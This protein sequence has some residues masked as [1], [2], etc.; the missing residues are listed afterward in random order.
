MLFYLTNKDLQKILIM[1]MKQYIYTRK[2]LL[3]L[4]KQSFIIK[5]T[6]DFQNT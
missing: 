5:Q 3:A 6:A 1:I 2:H 4:Q